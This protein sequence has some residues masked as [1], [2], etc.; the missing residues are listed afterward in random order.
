MG[1][2]FPSPKLKLTAR[3]QLAAAIQVSVS[4]VEVKFN[5]KRIL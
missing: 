2:T 5:L 3:L 1:I 4:K